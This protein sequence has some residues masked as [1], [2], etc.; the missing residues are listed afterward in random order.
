MKLL[1]KLVSVFKRIDKEIA[2]SNARDH[3]RQ[4]D[5]LIDRIVEDALTYKNKRYGS[6][7]LIS[8][9]VGDVVIQA[10]SFFNEYKIHLYNIKKGTKGGTI[11]INMLGDF[12]P[13]W[14]IKGYS[15]IPIK[16][17]FNT[18]SDITPENVIKAINI[19]SPGLIKEG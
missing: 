19:I 17:D 3:Q 1:R 9:R 7:K 11:T 10:H 18:V 8:E 13:R 5:G 4:V 6:E 14:F 2:Q 15:G 16:S 12:K